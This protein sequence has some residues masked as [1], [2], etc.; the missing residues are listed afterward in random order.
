LRQT[1]GNNKIVKIAI[2]MN[3]SSTTPLIQQEGWMSIAGWSPAIFK[4]IPAIRDKSS[5]VDQLSGP[6]KGLVK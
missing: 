3:A 2:N 4:W 5:A 6:Y 1:T